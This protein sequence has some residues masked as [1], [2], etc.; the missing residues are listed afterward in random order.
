M[1]SNNLEEIEWIFGYL[2]VSRHF[3]GF[4]LEPHVA[5]FFALFLP[6][7]LKR[8]DR[9]I[10][11]IIVPEFPL[12]KGQFNL[13]ENARDQNGSKNVDYVALSKDRNEV[14]FVELK[15][16]SNSIDDDQNAYL[17]EVEEGKIEFRRIVEGICE[18]AKASKN[19]KRKYV[20]LLHELQKLQLVECPDSLYEKTFEHDL[21]HNGASQGWTRAINEVKINTSD[22]FPEKIEVIFIL[23]RKCDRKKCPEFR[24]F[25]FF[26]EI[27]NS[28]R[29]KGDLA[30]LFETYLMFWHDDVA[31]SVNPR[32]VVT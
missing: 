3:P 5:P 24:N 2:N 28:I 16:D 1:P 30:D 9:C 22:T 15:T 19:R 11:D 27:A 26:D 14:Y 29:G 10:H 13:Y 32:E 20:H 31:G 21:P 7:I 8:I 18:M 12:R 17:R 25:I 4:R 23:P 6:D